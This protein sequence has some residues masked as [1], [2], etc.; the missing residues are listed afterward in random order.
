MSSVD[1]EHLA[2]FSIPATFVNHFR[3]TLSPALA[4]ITFAEGAVGVPPQ[5]RLA[6]TMH[7][8]DAKE[9]AQAISTLIAAMEAQAN[10]A[11]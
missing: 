1:P 10:V 11:H 4:R 3:V 8:Q 7:T 5:Y 9:L 2:A 6:V